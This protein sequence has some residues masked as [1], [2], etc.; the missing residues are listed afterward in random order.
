MLIG[1][2]KGEPFC[3]FGA[4]QYFRWE[5]HSA[6]ISVFGSVPKTLPET[7][8]SLVW[9]AKVEHLYKCIFS[10]MIIQQRLNTTHKIFATKNWP[11]NN[12]C[13]YPRDS[14]LVV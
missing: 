8:A 7:L 1:A 5:L 14:W 6:E 10:W 9:K 4:V 13:L 11:H 3:Y 2:S 12:S